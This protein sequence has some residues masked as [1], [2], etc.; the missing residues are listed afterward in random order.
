MDITKVPKKFCENVT[1]A[2]GQD[3]FVV[4]FV[5]GEAIDAYAM[6]PAHMKR[7]QQYLNHQVD[8][9]E[10]QNGVITTEPWDPNIKS[11]IQLR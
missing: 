8:A 3:H 6:T 1:V 2:F 9:F 10:K 7:L 5:S 11:P 4:G